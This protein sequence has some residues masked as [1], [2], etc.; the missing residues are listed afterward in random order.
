MWFQRMGTVG[1]WVGGREGGGG[2][3]KE[4]KGG[5]G[6]YQGPQC[7]CKSGTY[8]Y[9]NTS[10]KPTYILMRDER[11]KL[12]CIDIHVQTEEFSQKP[13]ASRRVLKNMKHT[14]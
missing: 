1:G 5:G 10:Y 2:G 6:D 3:G 12:A 4:R 11:R 9:I 14:T 7:T 8:N 13:F